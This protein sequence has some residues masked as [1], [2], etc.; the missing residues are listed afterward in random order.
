MRKLFLVLISILLL[1]S[2]SSVSQTTPKNISLLVSATVQTSPLQITFSWPKD[3]NATSY[4]VYRKT[5][6][7]ASWGTVFATLTGNDTIWIDNTLKSG[8]AFEYYFEK[9]QGANCIAIN[10]L[11]SGINL[12]AVDYRGTVLLLVDDAYKIKLAPEILRLM[13]DLVGDGWSVKRFYINRTESV[14]NVQNL[15]KTEWQKNKTI[16]T[17]FLL[18]HIPIPYSGIF[19]IPPDGHIV[20]SGG[21]TAAWPAD[22]YYGELTGKWTDFMTDTTASRIETRNLPDDGKFDQVKIPSDLEIEVGSVDL[23]QMSS[24]SSNDTFLIKRYLDKNHRFRMG[25]VNPLRQGLIDD[26]FTGYNLTAQG[27][28]AFSAMFGRNNI[29]D[30]TTLGKDYFPSMKNESYLW[31]CGSGAGWYTSCSGVGNST[32][33]VNDSVQTV[34]TMLTGSYFGDWNY[35]NNLLRAGLASK[36]PILVSFWGGIPQWYLHWMALGLNIGYCAKQTQNNLNV[37]YNG[38]FNNS[39]KG[40]HVALMGD[41]TLR[42][43]IVKPPKNLKVT[44]TS[45]KKHLIWNKSPDNIIGYNIYKSNYFWGNFTKITPKPITDTFYNDPISLTGTNI[46]IIRAVK[47]ETSSS[48]TYFNMSQGIFDSTTFLLSDK[49]EPLD[50]HNQCR[51][52][53][54]PSN[55]NINLEIGS[56]VHPN[57]TIEIFNQIGQSV[58][59]E[60]KTTTGNYYSCNYDL[61]Q[62]GKG[63]FLVRISVGNQS[64][65]RKIIIR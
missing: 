51:I 53:P 20:G 29:F 18:G 26:N 22:V 34:F 59:H 62:F 64:E 50:N 25:L 42:M 46:Y 32:N 52:Y 17:V 13:M 44:G 8:D 37:Y 28:R 54:N 55:G 61:S 7:S 1:S 57:L 5:F 2:Y 39:Y 36:S 4:K 3:A 38:N 35:P 19:T 15:I 41:P 49:S 6:F 23:F 11:Y 16:S 40:T 58:I 65:I 45:T 14:P 31:S 43:H 60:E 12:A 33:Y 10:Y 63:L 47:L 48:G 30:N 9:W 27:W 21:H 56:L 24:F